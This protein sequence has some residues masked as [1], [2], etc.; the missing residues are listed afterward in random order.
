MWIKTDH[1]ESTLPVDF[2][3]HFCLDVGPAPLNRARHLCGKDSEN[4]FT[5]QAAKMTVK[6]PIHILEKSFLGV[7]IWGSRSLHN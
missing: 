1:S 4:L 2:S 5:Y 7:H 6:R 3:A